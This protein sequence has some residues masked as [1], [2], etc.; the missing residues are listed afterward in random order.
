MKIITV[1]GKVAIK[2]EKGKELE[3]VEIT[4]KM[5]L[6]RH[7]DG[8][9]ETKTV[10]QLRTAQKVID[11]I[12]AGNGTIT[13]EDEQYKILKAACEKVGYPNGVGRQLLQYYDAVESAEEVKK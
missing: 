1:P 11:A 10:S 3:G 2:D 13:L 6:I 7:I 5:F 9:V 4:F 8:Y 12:E